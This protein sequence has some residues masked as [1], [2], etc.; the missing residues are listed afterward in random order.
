MKLCVDLCCGK[1][2]FSNAFVN[3]TSW[4]IVTSDINPEFEPTICKDIRDLTI[5]ELTLNHSDFEKVLILFSPPCERY[6]LARR[7]WPEHGI[8]TAFEIV[9]A[10]C[11]LIAD[12]RDLFGKEKLGYVIENPKARLR[13]FLGKP[14]TTINLADFGGK[15]RKPTDIWTNIQIQMVQSMNP[16]YKIWNQSGPNNNSRT[17]SADRAELPLGLSLAIKEAVST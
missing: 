13:W 8:R 11:E 9:G 17:R 14:K 15:Y 12:A 1:K 6:S 10:G 2:G 16:Y 7:T 5:Q 4:K 3:D